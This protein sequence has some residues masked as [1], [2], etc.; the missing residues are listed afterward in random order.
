MTEQLQL[1]R[2][3]ATQVA[4]F[5][6]AQGEIVVDTTNNRA[7]VNDGSTA[8][9]WPAAKLAEVLTNTRT[10]VSDAAY[11]ALTTDRL[12]A[13]T[14]LTAARVVTLPAASAYPTGTRLMIV[15]ESGS[16]SATKTITISCAGSDTI[17]GATSAV[18]ATTYGYLALEGNGSNAWT[19]VDT[20]AL[21]TGDSGSGGVAGLAPAP[22]AG[23]AASNEVLGA[24]GSWV[25]QMAGFRSRLRNASFAINQHAVSG[26]VSLLAGQYGHDGVKGGA[27]GCTYTF[28]TT[29]LDTTITISAGSLILPIESTLIEGGSYT[30]SQAGGAQARVW[31]GPGYT[32]TGSYATAPFTDTGLSAAT[33]TNLEFS[34]GTVLRPQLEP[35]AVAT[36]FERRR[37]SVELLDCQRYLIVLGGANFPT[38]AISATEQFAVLW[39]P[40]QMRAT[41]TASGYGTWTAYDPKIGNFASTTAPNAYTQ[42]GNNLPLGLIGFTGMTTGNSAVTSTSGA[43]VLSAEI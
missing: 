2:G 16:C 31:Q 3:T 43:L 34:T 38:L 11:A 41:P 25:G 5:T 1:R 22:P 32:G 27:S 12:V 10:A 28:A 6:G 9:G 23:S 4:A 14:T 29:G 18:I 39:L 36:A 20:A 15:D 13:Y 42:Y 19:I 17:N 7:V 35:G 33:Q 30:V 24:G 21:L 8:G 26:T 37:S 40:V